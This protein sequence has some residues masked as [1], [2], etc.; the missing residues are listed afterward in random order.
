MFD[1]GFTELLVVVVIAVVFLGPDKLPEVM[2]NIARFMRKIKSFIVNA[3]DTIDKE[4]QI[5]ELKEE[6]SRYRQDALATSNEIRKPLDDIQDKIQNFSLND[7]V[8]ISP[9]KQNE[10]QNIKNIK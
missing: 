7:E 5:Q 8:E 1:F 4:L 10:E 6:V 2:L 9:N 3:K